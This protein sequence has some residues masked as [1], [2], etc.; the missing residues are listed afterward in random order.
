MKKIKQAG[1][2]LH[3]ERSEVLH[4]L[5]SSVFISSF[6]VWLGY[7]SEEFRSLDDARAS[8]RVMLIASIALPKKQ[9][10]ECFTCRAGGIHH[11]I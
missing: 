11:S 3:S 9:S 5:R 4:S 1:A 7:I 6:S 2:S 8:L 10:P